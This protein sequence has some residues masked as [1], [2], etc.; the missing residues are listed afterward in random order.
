MTS[1]SYNE[2]ALTLPLNQ[3][4]FL[5]QD[6]DPNNWRLTDNEILAVAPGGA[7]AEA[8]VNL[9]AIALCETLAARYAGLVDISEGSASASLSQLQE[10][11]ERL[12][13]KLRRKSAS[14]AP[15]WARPEILSGEWPS[16]FGDP[17]HTT[18]GGA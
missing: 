17:L 9:A 15:A 8:S 16:A 3:I 13:I 10:K 11:Y 6:T 14:Q 7:M 1:Y 5:I 4:R 18:W 2:A 12:A